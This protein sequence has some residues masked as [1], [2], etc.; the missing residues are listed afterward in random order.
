MIPLP[1]I[2]EARATFEFERYAAMAF[3]PEVID[4]RSQQHAGADEARI[5][6]DQAEQADRDIRSLVQKAGH[7]GQTVRKTEQALEIIPSACRS[8]EREEEPRREQEQ[9]EPERD[10]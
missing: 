9:R 8:A 10:R 5:V 6:R 4:I 3:R 2:T 7:G 1:G